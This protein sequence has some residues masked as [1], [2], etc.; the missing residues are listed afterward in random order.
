MATSALYTADGLVARRATRLRIPTWR[1]QFRELPAAA[2]VAIGDG[3]VLRLLS[4]IHFGRELPAATVVAI[5]RGVASMTPPAQASHD[6]TL[7]PRTMRKPV[8]KSPHV[9]DFS[10]VDAGAPLPASA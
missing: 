5:G 7:G 1:P 10:F 8:T 3:G 6:Y 9:G 4:L 2:G